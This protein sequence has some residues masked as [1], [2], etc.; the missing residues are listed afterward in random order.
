MVC[1]TFGTFSHGLLSRCG[2]RQCMIKT[3]TLLRLVN[4]VLL[5]PISG[6]IH[7]LFGTLWSGTSFFGTLL[8]SGTLWY[9]YRPSPTLLRCQQTNTYSLSL[10]LPSHQF[11]G[12]GMVYYGTKVSYKSML[13]KGTKGYKMVSPL[14]LPPICSRYVPPRPFSFHHFFKPQS[15][16]PDRLKIEREMSENV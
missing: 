14:S 12:Y 10:S 5:L 13:Q 2:D 4:L 8:W 16:Q 9:L 15:F 6:K 11:A 1:L 7:F 3:P